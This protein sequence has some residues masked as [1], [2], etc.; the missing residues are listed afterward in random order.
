MNRALFFGIAMFF[1]VVGIA[2]VGADKKASA[3]FRH[4]RGCNGC[5][6]SG[7]GCDGGCS[8]AADSCGGGC[9]ASACCGHRKHCGGLFH[10]HKHRCNGCNGGCNGGGCNGGGCSAPAC[11][12]GCSG[13]A[14]AADAPAET[15]PPAPAA[16]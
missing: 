14:P 2:L 7:G 8:A 6:C 11:G 1:A 5:A 3:G 9:S 15:P 16:A 4:H 12:G 13:S 10:R